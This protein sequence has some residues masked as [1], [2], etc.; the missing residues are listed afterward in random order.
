MSF[1]PSWS[2]LPADLFGLIFARLSFRDLLAAAVVCRAWRRAATADELWAPYLVERL[3]TAHFPISAED[4]P[5]PVVSTA[6]GL[7]AMRRAGQLSALSLRDQ[8]ALCLAVGQPTL[9]LGR[10]ISKSAAQRVG[11]PLEC[12]RHATQY[13]FDPLRHLAPSWANVL[14]LVRLWAVHGSHAVAAVGDTCTSYGAT[15]IN[16]EQWYVRE[17]QSHTHK[18]HQQRNDCK[19]ALRASAPAHTPSG[20]R[21]ARA[22][23]ARFGPSSPGACRSF[24]WP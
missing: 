20:P 12:I 24:Y 1:A 5:P 17:Q 19:H 23:A 2:S 14:R 9:M 11:A 16:L 3:K 18:T 21:G 13:G 7:L 22:V 4:R 8:Y 15:T 6:E 10:L